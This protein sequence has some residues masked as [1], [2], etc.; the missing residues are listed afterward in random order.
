ML[1]NQQEQE[2]AREHPFWSLQQRICGTQWGATSLMSG[3]VQECLH[4]LLELPTG[5]SKKKYATVLE[6]DEMQ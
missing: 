1:N 3:Y 2:Q 6:G 4:A 5:S